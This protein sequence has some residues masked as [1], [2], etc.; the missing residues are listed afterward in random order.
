LALLK[1]FILLNNGKIE[2]VSDNGYYKIDSNG[3]ELRDFDG[4]FPGSCVN[5]QFNTNDK[6]SYSLVSEAVDGVF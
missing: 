6:N 1:E 4:S 5:V 2:V 3:E